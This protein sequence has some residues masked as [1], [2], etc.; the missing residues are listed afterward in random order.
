MRWRIVPSKGELE[1][2]RGV[3]MSAVLAE[4]DRMTVSDKMLVIEH[5]LRSVRMLPCESVSG[6]KDERFGRKRPNVADYIGYCQKFNHET[7]STD[8]IMRELREGEE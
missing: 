7:R 6:S 8:E 3:E 2:E 1:K 5:I 4:I